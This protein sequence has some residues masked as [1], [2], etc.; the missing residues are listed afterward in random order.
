MRLSPRKNHWWHITLYT[1]S[2]GFKTG[3]IPCPGGFESF[4]VVL[5]VHQHAVFIVDSL[6]SEHVIDVEGGLSVADFYKAFRSTLEDMGIP[7]DILARTYDVDPDARFEDVTDLATYDAESVQK[8]WRIMHWTD[9]V[10]QEFSGRT[11]AK[12]SP[13]QL[14]W[15]HLDL[16]VTRFSGKRG[17]PMPKEAKQADKEAYSH[18]VISFG[19]WAGDEN[20]QYPAFYSYTAPSPAGIDQE[21]LAPEAA[22]WQDA[23]GSPMA[24][25]AWED[26]RLSD[27]PRQTLLDFLESAWLAGA[28]R[29]GWPIDEL[30]MPAPEGM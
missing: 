16:A 27:D 9:M 30:T 18:E 10:F 21:P 25:L 17:A 8:F 24:L 2:R 28:Q 19:F 12:T 5:D 13:V 23:N 22:S 26:V 1:D 4:D 7:C 6:G 14:F 11:C 15:H 20:V 29:A 3:P